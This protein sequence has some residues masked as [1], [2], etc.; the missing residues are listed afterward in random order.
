VDTISGYVE[1]IVFRNEESGYTVFQLASDEYDTTTCVGKFALIG[2][3]EFLEIEGDFVD[4]PTY[5]PQM[6]V[7]VSRLKEPEDAAAIERYLGS[8]AIKGIGQK[9]AAAII[10][11]FG[12]D[13]FRVIEEEPERLAEVRGISLNKA[14]DISEQIDDKK[15]MRKAMLFLQKYGISNRLAAKIYERY[16]MDMY[17]VIQENPYRMADEIEG[18][19]FRVADEIASRVGIHADAEFRIRSGLL[20]TLRQAQGEGHVFLPEELLLSRAEKTLGLAG[21]DIAKFV[22]DL[23]IDRKVIIRELKPEAEKETDFA[24]N[25]A[26]TIKAVYDAGD[27]YM[28]WNSAV[29]LRELNAQYEVDEEDIR[30]KIDK[31]ESEEDIVLDEVQKK[32]VMETARNGILIVTGGP[33]TG[34]TTTIN[35]I[36]RFFEEEGKEIRLAAPTGRAARRMTEATGREASTIHRLLEVSAGI[37]DSSRGTVFER[38]A[39]NPLECDIVIID[40]MSMVDTR[41]MCSLLKAITIGTR[42]VLVGDTN[43]LPSVGAGRVLKDMI[44]SG[45]FNVVKLTKIFRQAATSD[46][47]V[48]AHRINQGEEIDLSNNSRDFFFLKRDDTNKIISNIITLIRDKLPPYVGAPASEIQVLTPTRKGLL[49]VERLNRILQ[50]YLNP[51]GPNKEEKEFGELVFR[52]G[53]KVMQIRNDYQLEW[54]IRGRNGIVVE[55]G[56]G[57]FNG[58]TGVITEINDFAGTMTVLFDSLR[59]VEYAFA[60]LDELELAYAITVHKAQGSEYPAVILPLMGGPALL[61]NRN[62]LY[63]AVT[64]ARK[65]VTILGDEEALRDMIRNTREQKRYTGLA[66]YIR[67]IEEEA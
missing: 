16:G 24:G 49:G 54:R 6:R 51:P 15:D 12:D 26:K 50:R 7:S 9:L 67:E 2:E 53:D 37:D 63:T 42:L 35:T 45:A 56:E 57:V 19:G 39:E 13:T 36:I 58:D 25:A 32:A 1:H 44:A 43:Q 55:K 47:I 30:K 48:N 11:K 20:Y 61:F 5:G 23:A 46:I 28:E 8:G 4:H 59:E 18:V 22:M 40:E 27:Y 14:R 60:S 29:M 41:L 34:K 10:K 21:A 52:D 33:G 64:R 31:I 17:S 3:G 38:N 62:L 65:C 66:F